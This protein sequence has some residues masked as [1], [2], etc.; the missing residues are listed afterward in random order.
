MSTRP[1]ASRSRS[2]SGGPQPGRGPKVRTDGKVDASCPQCGTKYRVAEAALDQKLECGECHRVF[3][4]KTTAGKRV[5]APDH[6]KTYMIFGGVGLGIVVLF[7]VMSGGS[8]PPKQPPKAPTVQRVVHT[9]SDNPRSHQ[10]IKW[11]QAIGTDNRLVLESHSDLAA[12]AKQVGVD[13]ARNRDAVFAA[14]Q[15]HDSTRYLRE[16]DCTDARLADEAMIESPAGGKATVSVTPKAGTDDYRKNTRGEFEVTFRMEGEQV[17]VT[18]WKLL[19]PPARNP[20]KPDPSLKTF[21]PNKDIAAAKTVEI[22]DSAGTRKVMESEPAPV[23]HWDK[24]SPE[25]R[26]K[27]DQVV[28]D[29]LRSAD[30]NAPGSLFNRAIRSMSTL[31]ERKAV[32]PR[33]L[34]AMYELYGDVNGNVMK[35]SQLDRALREWTGGAHN[36]ELEGTGDPEKDK[37]LRQS[38]IRQ[39]FAFWWRYSSGDLG[40]FLE[41]EE[42]LQPPPPKNPGKNPP[43]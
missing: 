21:V 27:A 19:M 38:C 40:E 14:L 36:F 39:W 11:G 13:D 31:D 3:F 15:S 32:V 9:P 20:N 24:A 26:A 7:A 43:K 18:G 4:P 8:P 29:V 30:D 25:L 41:K 17:K 37:K 2:G 33:A 5:K 23:P 10:L 34:N 22:S 1:P 16:L 42:S 12:I 28:A 35:I 6:S